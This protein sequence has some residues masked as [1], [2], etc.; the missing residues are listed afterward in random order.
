MVLVECKEKKKMI[1]AY[2]YHQKNSHLPL[3]VH[4]IPIYWFS[5]NCKQTFDEKSILPLSDPSVLPHF[6]S[7]DL[8][9]L[10]NLFIKVFLAR[11]GC[12]RAHNP[13]IFPMRVQCTRQKNY[14]YFFNLISMTDDVE[15]L[16]RLGWMQLRTHTH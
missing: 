9:Y 15:Y 7:K 4:L 6:I 2:H 11:F 13:S 5:L 8:N 14:F 3:D 16:F 1:L 10:H 12:I